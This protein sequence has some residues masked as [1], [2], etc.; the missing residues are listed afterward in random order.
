MVG[1]VSAGEARGMAEAARAFERSLPR[2]RWQYGQYERDSLR[3]LTASS[4]PHFNLFLYC[5][6]L[7]GAEIGASDRIA[8]TRRGGAGRH[9]A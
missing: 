1:S 2:W 7:V 3:R 5:R 6:V 4:E 9:G 8:V